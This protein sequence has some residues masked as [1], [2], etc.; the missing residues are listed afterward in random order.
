LNLQWLG[1]QAQI[2]QRL[3]RQGW[4]RSRFSWRQFTG[5]LNP[6][7]TLH[8]LPVTPHLH[9]GRY[10]EIRYIHHTPGDDRLLVLRL[11]PS[12]LYIQNKT[13]GLLPLWVGN[14]SHVQAMDYG[15][16]HFLKTSDEFDL[17]AQSFMHQFA[18]L[19]EISEVETASHLLLL[20]S[21]PLA[22]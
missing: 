7:A 2:E 14:V 20:V 17:A 6:A 8:S 13:P 3:A 15:L 21:D 11:W 4:T 9:E 22:E 10:D 18:P 5:W 16:M 1:E 19:L 12:A